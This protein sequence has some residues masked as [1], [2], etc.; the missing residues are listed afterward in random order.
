MTQSRARVSPQW[1]SLREPADARARS[2]E[3][4]EEVAAEVA[5]GLDD[6]ARPVVVHDLGSGTGSMGRWLAP[7]LRGPQHWVLHDRDP[8]L[9]PLAAT[10]PL[11]RDGD[12]VEMTV[13]TRQD[14]ITRLGPDGLRSAS[15]I[16]ASA[17]LDMLSVDELERL[18][19]SCVDADCPALISLSVTGRVR[20]IPPDAMD[21]VIRHAFNEHQRRTTQGRTLLGPVAARAAV[22][23]FRMMGSHVEVRA[24][25][26]RL[27]R[28][29]KE[30][31]GEW[32]TGWVGAACE[33]RHDLTPAA[34]D[35][36]A[37]RRADLTRG[38]LAVIV[39][40][41]DL[42]ARPHRSVR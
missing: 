20:L 40:H 41:V 27:E 6:G 33:Q 11:P 19:R 25:P 7:R 8:D 15:V 31:I 18:V 42:L 30:L 10:Q 39:Q 29:S 34:S 26:W 37:R 22:H 16:T 2:V 9:L 23:L 1:L 14:D 17:L 36:L 4:A 24:S 13:E 32:L 28:D 5:R 35:Y 21:S 38:R 3:L 12:G